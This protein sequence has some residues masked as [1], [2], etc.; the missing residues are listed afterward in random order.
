MKNTNI[1]SKNKTAASETQ[2][3][4]KGTLVMN[5]MKQHQKYRQQYHKEC[6]V[7]EKNLLEN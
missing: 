1:K 4:S 2:T 5:Q 6:S 7:K 3:D